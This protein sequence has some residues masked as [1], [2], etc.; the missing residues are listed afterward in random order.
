M[1]PPRKVK[2][3]AKKKENEN[4]AFRAFLKNMAVDLELEYSKV[5]SIVLIDY[6]NF[7]DWEA[8]A[9]EEVDKYLPGKLNIRPES[10]IQ[11][12]GWQ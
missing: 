5:L 2:F 3:W 7:K 8:C 12:R 9:G 11:R 4:Y 1:L 10:L 6:D